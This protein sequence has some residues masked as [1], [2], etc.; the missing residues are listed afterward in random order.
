MPGPRA[1]TRPSRG[2]VIA[3]VVERVTSCPRQPRRDWRKNESV[4]RP[5]NAKAGSPPEASRRFVV[6]AG[7]D[8]LWPGCASAAN[9]AARE[10]E[11]IIQHSGDSSAG[12]REREE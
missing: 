7:V 1:Q 9:N 4:R 5:T 11:R 6:L 12:I 8:L 10:H 3:R 2:T